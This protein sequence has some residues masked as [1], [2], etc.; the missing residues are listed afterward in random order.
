MSAILNIAKFGDGRTRLIVSLDKDGGA[1]QFF[2]DAM[3]SLAV[4]QEALEMVISVQDKKSWEPV[5]Q[6]VL[7]FRARLEDS[8]PISLA[9]WEKNYKIRDESDEYDLSDV[10]IPLKSIFENSFS[11]SKQG[12]DELHLYYLEYALRR[13]NSR[14]KEVCQEVSEIGNQQ[15]RW[16]LGEFLSQIKDKHTLEGIMQFEQKAIFDLMDKDNFFADDNRGFDRTKAWLKTDWQKSLL[17]DYAV[18]RKCVEKF[19]WEV[20]YDLAFRTQESFLQVK[21]NLSGEQFGRLFST[22]TDPIGHRRS[23]IADFLSENNLKVFAEQ[24]SIAYYL[25][26]EENKYLEI[27]STKRRMYLVRKYLAKARAEDKSGQHN[28]QRNPGTVNRFKDLFTPQYLEKYLDDD[29]FVEF[30][31]KEAR[32]IYITDLLLTE[33]KPENYYQLMISLNSDELTEWEDVIKHSWKNF[34]KNLS[35]EQVNELETKFPMFRTAEPEVKNDPNDEET[36]A[37]ILKL[38]DEGWTEAGVMYSLAT[39]FKESNDKCS[40]GND[41]EHFQKK[42][43]SYSKYF[44]ENFTK[45]FDRHDQKYYQSW[46]DKARGPVGINLQ[47]A[48][49]LEKLLSQKKSKEQGDRKLNLPSSFMSQIRSH[50]EKNF[51]IEREGEMFGLEY[52]IIVATKKTKIKEIIMITEEYRGDSNKIALKDYV[53]DEYLYESELLKVCEREGDELLQNLVVVHDDLKQFLKLSTIDHIVLN[54]KYKDGYM[55]RFVLKG[56]NFYEVPILGKDLRFI[57]FRKKQ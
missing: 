16:C 11:G 33:L 25:P 44:K 54:R 10:F 3:D 55:S 42:Y 20:L 5:L 9:T 45:E 14:W 13:E 19:G 22:W 51:P 48:K 36:L 15:A 37:F 41:F 49:E 12:T 35:E 21:D 38:L 1:R 32:D 27:V 57:I 6:S 50:V 46:I 8:Q 30:A 28:P 39:H 23:A 53:D 17:L 7:R 56:R 29:E 26:Y 47:K 2:K 52:K 24:F 31:M 40:K 43:V 4:L 18:E 34:A